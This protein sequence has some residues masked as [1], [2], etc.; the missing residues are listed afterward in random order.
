MQKWPKDDVLLEEERKERMEAQFWSNRKMSPRT[1]GDAQRFSAFFH[2]N[3][4]INI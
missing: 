2:S 4:K 1:F 3:K